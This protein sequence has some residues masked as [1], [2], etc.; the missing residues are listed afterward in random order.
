MLPEVNLGLRKVGHWA[1]LIMLH[2]A[3]LDPDYIPL[4]LVASLVGEPNKARLDLMVSEL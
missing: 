4:S 1:R 3:Y 2:I